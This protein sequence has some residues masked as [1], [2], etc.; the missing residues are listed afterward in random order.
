ME[1][2]DIMDFLCSSLPDLISYLCLVK[3]VPNKD[4][5]EEMDPEHKHY[6]PPL[7]PLVSTRGHCLAI[8]AGASEYPPTT[9]TQNL[10]WLSPY[11]S[12]GGLLSTLTYTH[13]FLTRS[14]ISKGDTRSW[15]RP[16][17]TLPPQ[18]TQPRN[19]AKSDDEDWDTINDFTESKA[20]QG[21]S[22][23][24]NNGGS[25]SVYNN[26]DSIIEEVKPVKPNLR[27]Q[28]TH[29]TQC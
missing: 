24:D 13:F 15:D 14:T 10:S 6:F 17:R 21:S 27:K 4:F 8:S 22:L 19:K 11:R 9:F 16:S 18:L 2:D 26:T 3:P 5:L 23:I 7:I 12:K 29:A 20:E 1:A 28:I 25:E